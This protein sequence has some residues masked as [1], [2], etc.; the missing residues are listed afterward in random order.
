MIVLAFFAFLSGIVTILSPCILPVLPLVLS[1]SVGGKSK[2]LG[3]ILGFVGSFSLFTLI[4]SVLVDV[5]SLSPEALRLF[6]VLIIAGFGVTLLFPALQE[7]L[8]LFLSRHVKAKGSTGRSGFGGGLLTGM[9][10]GLL[11]TP[12]VGP[13][14]ASVI[15]LAV[16]RRVDGGAVIIILAYSLGT[17]IPMF[18]LMTGGRVLLNRFPRLTSRI[19]ALQRAFGIIMI[20]TGLLIATGSDRKFQTFILEKLPRYGSGLTSLE[21]IKPVSDALGKRTG[22]TWSDPPEQARTGQYGAAP[23]LIAEGPWI[24][25]ETPLTME[26]LRGRVVLVDFWTYSCINCVRTI[27]YLKE[28]HDRYGDKGLVIIGVHSPEFPFER[29]R[30]NVEKAVKDLGVTWP[31]VLDN[32]FAQWHSYDNRFWPAHYFI[33]GEGNIRYFHFGE[34]SYEE[35]ERVIVSLLREAGYDPG[36]PETALRGDDPSGGITA[37]VYLGYN[38]ARGF[39]G[40]TL[41]RDEASEFRFEPAAGSGEWSLEGTWTVRN[42]FI[43]TAD[44]GAIR[45]AFT[46]GTAF[47]V[48]EPLGENITVTLEIDGVPGGTIK[49]EASGLYRLAKFPDRG[50]HELTLHIMGPARLYTFTFG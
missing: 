39:P 46:A 16:S 24:N 44:G 50:E 23:P 5:L 34:G 47:L 20:G 15:T 26:D 13:I 43:E 3:V 33:D 42:D 9:S 49:P 10:L 32:D 40:G 1:G 14:M 18:A 30:A 7:R 48:M 22:R 2:P 27:P 17:A 41:P 6:A 8:E 12:C 28:W 37:E 35:S 4:L 31:V 25:S 21:Q 11:W 36:E 38:R 29:N 45:L 19:G